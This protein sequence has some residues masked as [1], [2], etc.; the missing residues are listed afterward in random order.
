MFF[1]FVGDNPILDP[2]IEIYKLEDK[3]II[4]IFS[5]YPPWAFENAV[6]E[7]DTDI[8][9]EAFRYYRNDSGQEEII[10]GKAKI[11]LIDDKWQI[12]HPE[13]YKNMQQEK[14]GQN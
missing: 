1:A 8:G 6:W 9:M 12:I 4:K 14:T 5:E 13:F 11:Q 7:N 2:V 10:K 3:K